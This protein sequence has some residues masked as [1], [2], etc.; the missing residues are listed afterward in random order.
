MSKRR[1]P[2]N[3]IKIVFLAVLVGFAIYF[4]QVI[5]P[6]IQPL[7]VP[8]M[9]P[10][11]DPESYITDAEELFKQGKLTQAIDAYSQVVHAQPKD[12]ASYIAMARAQ[13]WAGKYADAQKSAEYALLLNP[14]NSTAH[15]VRGWALDFQK[16]FLASELSIKRALELDDQNALAHA[17]YAELLAD[18]YANNT[19]PLDAVQKASD[20]SKTAL[21][22][23]PN[24]LEAHRARGYIYYMTQNYEL[25]IAE[26]QAAIAINK[27][28]EDLQL[29][30]GLNYRAL[31]VNDKAVE[32]FSSA[33]TLNPADPLPNLYISRVYAGVG[34]YA[35]ALQYAQQ[36]VN[37]MPTDTSFHGNLG[38]MLYRNFKYTEAVSELSLVVKGGATQDGAILTPLELTDSARVAEYYFIYGLTLAKLKPPRCGEALLIAQQILFKLP[39]DETSVFNANEIIRLCSQAT[40]EPAGPGTPAAAVTPGATLTLTPVP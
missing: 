6:T 2:F 12:A 27:N 39:G 15:A 5:I 4:N 28:I 40:P 17:Y 30:L 32:A 11:R 34:E 1:K 24:L 29:N 35:K 20:E 3:V 14:N 37:I 25:A 7:G 31:A 23:G 22:L 13:V 26:Y 36:A 19:G 16:D 38:V 8:T 21:S 33:S 9:T 18:Q 10:T